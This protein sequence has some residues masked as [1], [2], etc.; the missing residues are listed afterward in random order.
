MNWWRHRVVTFLLLGVVPMAGIT[1]V[2]VLK[3]CS[4]SA[5]PARPAVPLAAQFGDLG[6]GYTLFIEP[7]V[8]VGISDRIGRVVIPTG[9]DY[10]DLAQRPGRIFGPGIVGLTRLGDVWYGKCEL[11]LVNNGIE[12]FYFAIELSPCNIYRFDSLRAADDY[13]RSKGNAR[14]PILRDPVWY[15]DE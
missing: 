7:R 12:S 9:D 5:A 11:S 2:L 3:E 6:C 1:S 13:A 15:T 10:S 14:W 4:N 8:Y